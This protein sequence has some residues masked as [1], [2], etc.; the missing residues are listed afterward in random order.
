VV[1]PIGN[2]VFLNLRFGASELV[3]RVA[4]RALPTAGEVRQ[5][6][7]APDRLHFFDPA[8]GLRIDPAG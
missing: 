4:P 5:F 1:E 3:A 8:N 6:A 7:L 2:E